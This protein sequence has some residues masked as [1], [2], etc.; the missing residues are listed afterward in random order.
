MVKKRCKFTFLT[1]TPM[2]PA[3][4]HHQD[5]DELFFEQLLDQFTFFYALTV[6]GMELYQITKAQYQRAQAKQRK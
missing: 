1:V 4:K 2:E 5:Q 3:P 6:A